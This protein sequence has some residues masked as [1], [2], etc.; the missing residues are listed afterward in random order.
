MKP[1][2]PVMTFQFDKNAAPCTPEIVA[3]SVFGVSLADLIRDI[4]E[5]RGGKYGDLYADKAAVI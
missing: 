2:K 1:E 3:R 4:Q 5:N